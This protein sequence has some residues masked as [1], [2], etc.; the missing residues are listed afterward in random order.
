[1]TTNTTSSAQD[2]TEKIVVVPMSGDDYDTCTELLKRLLYSGAIHAFAYED[3][4]SSATIYHMAKVDEEG[5][6]ASQQ[7]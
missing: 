5:E 4:I 6:A 1:M 2:M 3:T 7:E